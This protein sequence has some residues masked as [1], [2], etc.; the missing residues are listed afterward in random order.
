VAFDEL[1]GGLVI[2]V[3]DF[4]L[5]VARCIKLV[6]NLVSLDSILLFISAKH[7]L[8]ACEVFGM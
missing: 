2:I 5:P 4:V 7:I 6:P 3:F 8:V 1:V